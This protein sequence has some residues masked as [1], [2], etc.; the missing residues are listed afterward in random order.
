MRLFLSNQTAHQMAATR[1]LAHVPAAPPLETQASQS[2]RVE[3]QRLMNSLLGSMLSRHVFLFISL[4]YV[5][6][7]YINYLVVSSDR[8]L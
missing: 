8:I 1:D 3:E 6:C 7:V 5:N 2:P 4:E